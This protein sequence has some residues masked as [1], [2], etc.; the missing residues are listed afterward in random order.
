[1]INRLFEWFVIQSI[2][3]SKRTIGLSIL[4]T[5]LISFGM[6]YLIIE[7]DMMKMLPKNIESKIIWD[8]IQNEFGSTEIIFIAFGD[9]YSKILNSR[10]LASLWALSESLIKLEMVDKV[11]SISTANR[12]ENIDDFIEVYP[13]QEEQFLDKKSVEDIDEYLNNN[14]KL[15]KQLISKRGDYLLT[16]VQPVKGVPLDKLTNQI[17]QNSKFLT[18]DYK[19]IYG[20]SAYITGSLPTLIRED[21]KLLVLYGLIIMNIIL[22]VNLRSF[23]AILLVFTVIF[24]S[25][26]V[27]LGSMGWLYKLTNSD[28]FLF[29]IL[30]TSMPIILLTIANSDGVHVVTKFFRELRSIKSKKVAIVNCMNSLLLPLFLTTVTTIAAFLTMV[31]SPLE[32]LIGYGIGISIGIF[33]AWIMSSLMLPA[34]LNLMNWDLSS[35]EILEP[36]IFEKLISQAS[37]G[38]VRYPVKIFIFGGLLFIIGISGLYRLGVDVNISSFFKPDSEIRKSIGFMDNE[39]S[40]TMDLRVLFQ[41][42]V[43]DPELLNEMDEFQNYISKEENVSLVYSIVDIIKQMHRTVINEPSIYDLLPQDQDKINNLFT[44][45]SLSGDSEDF[46]SFINYS[47]NKGLLTAFIRTMTTEEIFFFFTQNSIICRQ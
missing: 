20:G 22:F 37:F 6:K 2:N 8:D 24:S 38:I 15:K 23:R 30:S 9:E 42:N 36:S 35:N 3:H 26:L 11:S 34:L 21:T 13:L 5:L 32:T 16:I 18:Q 19:I 28:R 45:Y 12:M 14:L 33:W 39:M 1:M 27:M 4:F 41:G 40:G 46:T 10:A 31:M 25:L 17:V 29:A 47:Y 7:D 44:L 43:K